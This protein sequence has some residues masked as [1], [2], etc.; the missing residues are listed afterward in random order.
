MF[1]VK[2]HVRLSCRTVERH[3]RQ[4]NVWRV[5]FMPYGAGTLTV[6]VCKAIVPAPSAPPNILPNI[7][8]LV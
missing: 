7:V 6:L 3:A 8:A 2:N 5:D 1:I 4:T